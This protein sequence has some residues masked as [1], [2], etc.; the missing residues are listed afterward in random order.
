MPRFKINKSE[1]VKGLNA[2]APAII[3]N[4][5]NPL[6]TNVLLE[7]K[8]EYLVLLGTNGDSSIRHFIPCNDD[9]GYICIE[10][11]K[12]AVPGVYFTETI[13]TANK[14][15]LEIFDRTSHHFSL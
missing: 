4:P 8:T 15:E 3:V 1:L 13:K 6:M 5:K 11:G 7:V 14:E 2:V 12:I 9:T 10:D